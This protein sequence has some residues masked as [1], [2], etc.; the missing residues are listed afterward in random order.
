MT[1]LDELPQDYRKSP[2][3]VEI[4]NALEK[5]CTAAG[6]DIDELRAQFFLSTAT[7][8]LSLWEWILG[9]ET[10]SGKDTAQRRSVILAKLRGSGTTTVAML[11]NVSEAFVNGEAAIVEYN[12]ESRFDVVMLSVIGIPPNMEDLKLVI[13]EI[14]PA[15]LDYRIVLK[16]NT[17]GMVAENG[18]RWSDIAGRKWSEVREV[19][20]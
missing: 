7:W 17:W 9:I 6:A 12:E 4:Q 1:F 18:R 8:G 11:Q 20:F 15:H 14:K 5:I 16:Y 2:A 13:E 10:E 19:S 3:V